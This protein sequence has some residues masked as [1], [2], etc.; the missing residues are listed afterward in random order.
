MLGRDPF[1]QSFGDNQTI[2]GIFST[3]QNEALDLQY[4]TWEGVDHSHL[5]THI[6]LKGLE[7]SKLRKLDGAK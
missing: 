3:F 2:G 4:K 5:V 7:E 1:Y 6:H